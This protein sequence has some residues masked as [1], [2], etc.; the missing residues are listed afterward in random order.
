[1][2]VVIIGSGNVATTLGKK[3][4]EAGTEIVQVV[5]R[6]EKNAA[7][8]ASILFSSHTFSLSAINKEADIYIV[9]V[10]DSRVA[11]I[12]QQLR[13]GNK[14]IVHTAASVSKE[15]LGI[16][17]SNYGVLYPLQSLKKEMQT[18]PPIPILVDANNKE[19][20]EFLRTFAQQ[21]AYN[22]VAAKDEERLRLHVAAVFA[23]NFANHILT[24]TEEYCKEEDLNFN[25]LYP[26]IEETIGRAKSVS[27]ALVQ[28]GPAIRRD[29][30]TVSKHLQILKSYPKLHKVYKLMTDSIISHTSYQ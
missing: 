17:S 22:V 4:K 20:L 15:V 18:I 11:E 27:P 16:A 12:A 26:L 10:S 2:K 19:T 8:L 21:W 9:A 14:I 23:S 5:S 24:L 25:L 28:T 7:S 3:I 30:E 6:N 13:L 1:M 29:M